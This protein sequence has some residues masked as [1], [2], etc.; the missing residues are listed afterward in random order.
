MTASRAR[1]QPPCASP[2]DERRPFLR[3]IF[4]TST[5]RTIEPRREDRL[6]ST[7]L[8]F[9]ALPLIAAGGAGVL[10]GFVAAGYV[11]AVGMVT[12]LGVHR[13]KRSELDVTAEEEEESRAVEEAVPAL[14][15]ETV[16]V[17]LEFEHALDDARHERDRAEAA[18]LAKST[19]LANMS[20]EIRTPMTGIIGMAEMLV[21]T[22]LDRQQR[23]YGR[24][25]L[26]SAS[27]L[28]RI[29]D[30]IL[31]FS[32][33][34][35]GKLEIEGK[36]FPL[37]ACVREAVNLHSPRAASRDVELTYLLDPRVPSH[38][39]GDSTRVRQILSN[40]LDNALEFTEEGEVHLSV[41]VI[42]DDFGPSLVKFRVRD[43]GVGIAEA[44]KSNLF[45]PFLHTGT[46]EDDLEARTGLGLA[47][48]R[49]L[50][51]LMGG[52]MGFESVHAVGST[53][54][55]TLPLDESDGEEALCDP[56]EFRGQRLL[57]VDHRPSSRSVVRSLARSW[58]LDVMEADKGGGALELLRAAVAEGRPFD[59]AVLDEHVPPFGGKDLAANIKSD[60]ALRGTGLILVRGFAT[61]EAPGSL[62][63]AGLD[64]WVSKPVGA[65]PLRETLRYVRSSTP[66][67]HD[68]S[69]PAPT[70]PPA[71]VHGP[72]PEPT[73]AEVLV[74]EDN[75]VNQRV[76]ALLL[77]KFGCVVE[78]AGDGAQAV[79]LVGDRRFDIV[80][81][82]CRMPGVDGLD[83]TVQI[84][85]L[86]CEWASTIPI[87]AM[88]AD[89]MT[90]DRQQCLDA[91]MND[92]LSKP[93]QG[94]ELEAMV[95]KWTGEKRP[96]HSEKRTMHDTPE[97]CVIDMDVVAALKELGGDD[98]PDL[99]TELVNLF[100]DDTPHRLQDLL[101]GL[102]S[103]DPDAVRSAAH[104]LKSSCANLGAL[105][106]S[107]LFQAIEAAGRD[108]DLETA[109]P[110]FEESQHE[111]QRV[112]SALRDIAS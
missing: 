107:E 8:L 41:D 53:F 40:L 31:D 21:G 103:S 52:D 84:R 83:A 45:R 7:P 37:E 9:L 108:E 80:F 86:D 27:G 55:F 89:T 14:P 18:S 28:L 12:V 49:N 95:H 67:D 13:G 64:A 5:R 112:E 46:S 23:E 85:G 33:I 35:I 75:I 59:F 25:I 82:D 57:V 87:V 38:L 91:G 71:P 42:D 72:E 22:E 97:D 61:T 110:L 63:R 29:L 100:L 36:R 50:V 93:V 17:D 102:E 88:T 77:H 96:A 48:S 92:F 32:K 16:S 30:D 54:W 81:M 101:Q 109:A 43:T 4:M 105:G 39:I 60:Q 69:V 51:E 3:T 70:L 74:V 34:E 104:A 15:Q 10:W 111:F 94:T 19:F 73:G 1:A 76:A 65:M 66:E 106:L 62:A 78:L 58:H 90:G 24:T 26:Q 68:Y 20:H 56:D 11:L 47:L 79:A 99:F 98:D 6:G 2:A 44:D